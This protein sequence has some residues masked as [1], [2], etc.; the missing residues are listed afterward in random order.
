MMHEKLK[1][2][3]MGGW[4]VDMNGYPYL[5]HPVTDGIPE[6]D[7]DV[8]DEVIDWMASACAFDCDL[9]ITPES[10]GIPLAV[11]LSLRLR[12]PY[13]IIRKRRYGIEGEVPV[14]YK[15]GYSEGKMYINGPKRGDRVV[16]VD[17][18]LSNGGTMSAIICAL[19][20]NGI[21]VTDVLTV[22]NK[23]SVREELSRRF[24]IEFKRMLDISIKDGVV[25]VMGPSC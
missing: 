18:I 8:L 10:M 24:G 20:E 15:T 6:M 9:I 21:S 4:V 7:P 13:S 2:S 12:I 14:V 17:D 11:P 19:R 25:T 22:F 3:V 16:I 5:I 23:G 1:A